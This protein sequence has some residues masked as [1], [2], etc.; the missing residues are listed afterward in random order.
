MQGIQNYTGNY[1]QTRGFWGQQ[2]HRNKHDFWEEIKDFI[3]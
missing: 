3:T 2:N 1:I